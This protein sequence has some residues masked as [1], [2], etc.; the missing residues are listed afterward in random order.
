MDDGLKIILEGLRDE[1]AATRSAVATLAAGVHRADLASQ[2]VETRLIEVL[3]RL[4]ELD[5]ID[6]R[7]SRMEAKAQWVKAWSAGAAAAVV[8]VFGVL[9][10]IAQH[11]PALAVID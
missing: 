9:A 2:R 5:D 11:L 4:S 7:I 6:D 10:W 8:A 1:G 3:D